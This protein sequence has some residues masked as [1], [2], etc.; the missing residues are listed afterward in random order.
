MPLRRN[1]AACAG[2]LLAV[3]L[4]LA[5]L[6]SG[7]EPGADAKWPTDEIVRTGMA[8]IRKATRDN[9]TLVTHRRMPPASARSFADSIAKEARRIRDG[10]QIPPEA[11]QDLEPLLDD[12]VAGAEAVAG[13]GGELTPI[14]GIVRIDSALARYPVR[15][16]DPTWQPLR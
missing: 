9:H 15:F 7:A 2:P 4:G 10:A 3:A 16:D 5:G 13:R 6:A 11:R 8:A 1:T 12:I 14:D